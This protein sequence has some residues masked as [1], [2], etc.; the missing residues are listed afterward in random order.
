MV[1]KKKK[2]IEQPVSKGYPGGHVNQ[3]KEKK[4]V[5]KSNKGRRFKN[6]VQ[7]RGGSNG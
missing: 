2:K 7:I 5:H 1:K 6:P 3:G 4:K